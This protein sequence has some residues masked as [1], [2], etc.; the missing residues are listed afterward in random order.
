MRLRL[1]A[2][3]LCVAA[4]ALV[5][6]SQVVSSRSLARTLSCSLAHPLSRPLALALS[7]ALSGARDAVQ[8]ARAPTCGP[9]NHSSAPLCARVRTAAAHLRRC[10]PGA[11]V[12]RP[13]SRAST[14]EARWRAS[15]P[16]TASSWPSGPSP[17]GSRPVTSNLLF[18]ACTWPR[19]R[20]SARGGGLRRRGLRGAKQS[21][22]R[23]RR[24]CR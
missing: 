1:A 14:G 4:L 22:P 13:S 17:M 24:R 12:L 10:W 19:A 21:W 23:P 15:P 9:R 7:L 3:A 8:Y 20:R 11:D 5:A 16:R 2:V 6:V 18:A